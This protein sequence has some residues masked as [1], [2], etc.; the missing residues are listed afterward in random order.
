[1]KR[2][3]IQVLCKGCQHPI[4]LGFVA[5]KAFCERS[6]EAICDECESEIR[7]EIKQGDMKK[8]LLARCQMVKHT[9][10]LLKLLKE[11]RETFH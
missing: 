8:Q 9:D 2:Y 10:K 11:R 6:F 7:I 5:P 4:H 1:M 3:T